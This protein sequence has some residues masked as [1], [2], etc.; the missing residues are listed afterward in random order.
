MLT[1]ILY[2]KN[3]LHD[4]QNKLIKIKELNMLQ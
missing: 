2:E 4:M 1:F 3:I